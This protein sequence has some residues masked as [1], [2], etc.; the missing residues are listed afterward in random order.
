MLLLLEGPNSDVMIGRIYASAQNS[1]LKNVFN[2]GN[3]FNSSEEQRIIAVQEF[4]RLDCEMVGEFSGEWISAIFYSASPKD[5]ADFDARIAQKQAK[6]K[7]TRLGR[8]TTLHH[9]LVR[10]SD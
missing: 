1:V 6:V 4:L 10:A 5:L 3:H 8:T 7:I 2:A 9:M